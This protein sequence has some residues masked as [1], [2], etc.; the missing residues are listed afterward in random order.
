M[1]YKLDKVIYGN[2]LDSVAYSLLTGIP[3]ICE[4][5]E[6]PETFE[7]FKTEHHLELLKLTNES[8]Q[9]SVPDGVLVLNDSKLNV[10]KKILFTLSIL[11]KVKFANEV[12]FV[13]LSEPN[14]L[15]ICTDTNR[16]H[17]IEFDKLYVLNDTALKDADYDVV[18]KQK[19]RV[20]ESFH[21]GK[22]LSFRIDLFQNDSDILKNVYLFYKET[23]TCIAESFIEHDKIN[24]LENSLFYVKHGLMNLF[25]QHGADYSDAKNLFTPKKKDVYPRNK[26]KYN[27]N[28]FVKQIEFS[29][30]DYLC[31]T[32]EKILE[33][34]DVYPLIVT[35]K[36]S[37]MCT[38]IF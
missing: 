5:L 33:S 28:E 11:G 13:S 4:K 15:K 32:K 14:C 23:I 19:S 10:F 37:E 2:D 16:I 1:R 30:E 29:L 25:R 6:Y 12:K 18:E 31:G 34:Q 3:I 38:Q 7:Y 26:I 35:H 21:V 17:E 24:D 9:I 27:E 8:Y 20:L 36:F 22:N